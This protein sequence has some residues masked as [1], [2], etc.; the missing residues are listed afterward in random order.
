MLFLLPIGIKS[1][2]ID[3]TNKIDTNFDSA[4]INNK[5]IL[6]CDTF[7]N[8]SIPIDTSNQSSEE[9]SFYENYIEPF[10]AVVSV[11]LVTILLFSVRS[12]K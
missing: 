3:S 9:L 11:A 7:G 10:I 5:S 1:L 12:K 8:D 4:V 2:P 6:P